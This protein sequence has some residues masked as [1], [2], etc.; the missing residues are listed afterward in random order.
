MSCSAQS[1]F[2]RACEAIGRPDLITDARYLN[3]QTRTEHSVTLDAVFAE[4]I[5]GHATEDV[6]AT[7]ND[8]GAAVTPVSERH[9]VFSTG[10]PFHVAK[11]VI[12]VDDQDLGSTIRM[13]NVVPKLSRTPGGI[14]HAGPQLGEH[15]HSGL[16]R[17]A[18][19]DRCR[20]RRAQR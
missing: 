9:G 6:L 7:L 14:R 15:T 20:D 1:V 17:L 2:V 10:P 18:G 13:Q 12:A 19:P 16:L 8:T 4:W 3:N 11:N 5:S